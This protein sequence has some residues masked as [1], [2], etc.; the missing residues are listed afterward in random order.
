MND[1]TERFG[2]ITG[3]AIHLNGGYCL[4]NEKWQMGFPCI[5]KTK[6]E[7]LAWMRFCGKKGKPVKVIIFVEMEAAQ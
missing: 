4:A 6:R 5:A 3:W 2:P 7:A 1:K